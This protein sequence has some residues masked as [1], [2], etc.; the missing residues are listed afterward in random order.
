MGEHNVAKVK[1]FKK[2]KVSEAEL[3]EQIKEKA[4]ELWESKGCVQGKDFEIWLEAE[5]L[6]KGKSILSSQ[7][8]NGL[9]SRASR[10]NAIVD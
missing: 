3:T 7:T 2:V 10:P 1:G 8:V 6:V 5:I 4:K 9:E